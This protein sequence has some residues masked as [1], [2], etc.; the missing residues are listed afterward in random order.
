MFAKKYISIGAFLL[1]FLLAQTQTNKVREHT[2]VLIVLDASGSMLTRWGDESKWQSA[3]RIVGKLADS[4]SRIENVDVGLRVY[5][6]QHSMVEKNCDDTKL[7]I[8]IAHEN[9]PLILERLKKLSPKGITPIAFSL[10]KAA[11]DFPDKNARNNIILIT[12][13][14][15]SCFGDPCLMVRLLLQEGVMLK[16]MIIGL[17]VPDEAQEGFECLGNLFNAKDPIQFEDHLRRVADRVLAQSTL[18]VFLMDDFGNPTETNV[19][20]T[21]YDADNDMIRQNYYHLLDKNGLPD[22]ME[23]DHLTRYNIVIHTLPQV[24]INNVELIPDQNNIVRANAGQGSL[25]IT[26]KGPDIRKD[27]KEKIKCVVCGGDYGL[28][29][30]SQSLEDEVKY[31]TGEYSLEILTVPPIIKKNV[32][33]IQSVSTDIEIPSPGLLTLS[34]CDDYFG[35]IFVEENGRLRKIYNLKDVSSETIGIL[36]GSYH[37]L[38]RHKKSKSMHTSVDKV[39]EIKS[40]ESLTLRL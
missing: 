17:N 8:P 6:H 20:M 16:P 24:E 21:F 29:I 27:V 18:Q 33:I 9:G 35:G 34:D 7:E 19:N 25:K 38:Y 26:L 22:S 11:A 31:R 5:G 15:E 32:A 1:C 40:G 28:T 2:R 39:F 14:A 3:V 12:D 10:D 36:P 13:G 37:L 23:I 4:L 30:N